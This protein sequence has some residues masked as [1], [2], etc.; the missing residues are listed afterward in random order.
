MAVSDAKSAAPVLDEAITKAGVDIKLHPK[1]QYADDCYLLI[2]QSQYVKRDFEGA[3]KTFDYVITT[4]DPKSKSNPKNKGL[5]A[6]E[7][8]KQREQAA[9]DKKK[10]READKKARAKERELIKE[11]RKKAREARKKGDKDATYE[12][13]MPKAKEEKPKEEK[14][15]KPKKYILK[16]R[17]IRQDAM[18]WLART[19]IERGKYDE[20]KVWISRLQ[21]DKTLVKSL[22]GELAAINAYLFL[23]QKNYEGAIAP[24]EDAIKNAKNRKQK[25]RFAF[26]L[27]QIHQNAGR[28]EDAAIAFQRVIKFR[29]AYEMEFSARLNML[30]N[31]FS[32]DGVALADAEKQLLKLLKD[33][34]NEEYQDQIYYTLA[35]I[36]FKASE[37]NKAISYLKKSVYY[38]F[39]NQSQKSESYLK[40][41]DTY[42]TKENYV[43]AKYYYDSTLTVIDKTDGRF[44]LV[45]NRSK[46]L[47]DIAKNIQIIEKQDSFLNI[48]SLI[49]AEKEKEY[50][51]IAQRILDEREKAKA[52][53]TKASKSITIAKTPTCS[54]CS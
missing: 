34:K 44:D 4:F 24:L 48:K 30:K 12:D 52:L 20:A 36:A 51:S 38:N 22:R 27:A 31:T 49:D 33:E 16:H 47:T 2:G 8:K 23:K 35:E 42:Y 18:I 14:G 21:E 25:A 32:N 50:M 1:S 37:D 9:K 6:K 28:Q 41:A 46:S 29:P 43:D 15:D 54:R 19:K 17:P 7:K 40:L 3:E 53:L 5:S 26:I 11:A 13:F 39:G 10:Q 45:D